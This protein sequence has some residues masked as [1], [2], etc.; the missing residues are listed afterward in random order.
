MATE[1]KTSLGA[2]RVRL[3]FNPSSNVDVAAIKRLTAALIDL[4]IKLDKGNGEQRRIIA[5]ANNAYEEAA[6]WAVKAAI[7][8]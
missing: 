3:D 7:F 5:L 4:C 1:E 6:M 8:G 2:S